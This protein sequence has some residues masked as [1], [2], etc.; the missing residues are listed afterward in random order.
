MRE[1]WLLPN[2]RILW[3]SMLL[4]AMVVVGAV[5]ALVVTRDEGWSAFRIVSLVIGGTG[6]VM[7][8][9]L[10]MSLR[11]PR[12]AYESA[13]LLVYLRAGRPIRV[14]IELVEV[15]FMGQGPAQPS[16]GPAESSNVVVR[17][18][19]RAEE[20]KRMD[21]KPA[22]GQWC[23]GYITIRGTW[24]EPLLPEVVERLNRRLVAAHRAERNAA[25]ESAA[26]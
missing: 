25:N 3:T 12:L 4:P 5:I 16:G 19:E 24:C 14:P 23:D 18:A 20:W 22:L 11:T 8:V 6:L 2:Q 26:S 13:H 21:V 1:T 15:F 17:L 9:L 10:W 7:I